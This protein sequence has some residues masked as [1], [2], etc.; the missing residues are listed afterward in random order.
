MTTLNTVLYDQAIELGLDME[1]VSAASRYEIIQMI[2]KLEKEL[3]AQVSSGVTDW[4]KARIAKQLSEATRIIQQYYDE[5]SGVMVNTTTSVAQVSAT[6]TAQALGV[7][8]GN[9][10]PTVMP[11]AAWLESIASNVIVQGAT[12]A[13]WWNRQSADTAWRFS[14]AVR[15]GLVSAET[16]QQIIRRVMDVMDVSRKNAAALVQTSVQSVS[17]QAKDKTRQA[18]DHLIAS[19]EWV[20]T[21]DKIVCPACGVRDGKRW[22]LDKE[23]KGHSIPYQLPPLHFNCLPAD[24]LITSVSNITGAS[25]RWMDG[26]LIIIKTSSGRELSCTPNHPILTNSGWIPANVLNVGD[27]VVANGASEWAGSSNGDDEYIPTTIHEITESFFSSRKVLPR[28]VPM[29]AKDFHGDGADSKVGIVYSDSFLTSEDDTFIC[30]HCGDR[31]L[32][33]GEPPAGDALNG[34]SFEQLRANLPLLSSDRVMRVTGERKPLFGGHPSN[35]GE[36]LLTS[37]PDVYSCILECSGNNLAAGSKDSSNASDSNTSFI[38][39]QSS[40]NINSDELLTG[41]N[42]SVIKPIDNSS[43]INIEHLSNLLAGFT[44]SMFFDEIISV[45][46]KPFHGYVLNIETVDGWYTAN[47]IITHNCRCT[48]VDITKTWREL[49]IDIDEA[50]AGTRASMEG[51]VSDKTFE[52]FLKRKGTAYQNEVLGKGRAEL[53]RNGTITFNQLLNQDGNMLTLKELEIKYGII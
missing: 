16:N 20:A 36:L 7:A 5:M 3:I 24:S 6:S 28:P 25:K 9:F 40:I 12:Q 45:E 14:T 26:N 48:T 13:A 46:I 2:K 35:S 11:S 19:V 32:I 43:N 15:Q 30:Q 34:L 8:T 37:V 22:G 27:N 52:E 49:G 21:L 50:P 42:A 1:R 23:P 47:G 51:Q 4:N 53:Y 29:T 41:I 44:G 38:D 39:G 31:F 18:N 10:I 33:S 17:A